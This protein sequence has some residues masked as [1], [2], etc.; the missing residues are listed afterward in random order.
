MC[1]V[2]EN[3]FIHPGQT[4]KF[5]NIKLSYLI[6]LKLISTFLH[7]KVIFLGL[8]HYHT[9]Q[10][11]NCEDLAVTLVRLG[12]WPASPTL[13]RVAFSFDFMLTLRAMVLEGQISL[14]SFCNA[15]Q[16]TRIGHFGKASDWVSIQQ[17]NSL[18]WA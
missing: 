3:L 18:K 10:A 6:C 13:P 14:S 15:M 11:C 12:L 5:N 2:F 7:S 1:I 4:N 9:M 17:K 16:D 8:Q